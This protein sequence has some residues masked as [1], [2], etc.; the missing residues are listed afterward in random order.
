MDGTMDTKKEIKI[1]LSFKEP[2]N[3][4]Q[5]LRKLEE[6]NILIKK[7]KEELKKAP[8]EKQLDTIRH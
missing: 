3:T 1:S 8:W 5:I 2:L 7:L 4:E 6:Q